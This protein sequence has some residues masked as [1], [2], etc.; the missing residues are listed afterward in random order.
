MFSTTNV[1]REINKPNRNEDFNKLLSI[2]GIRTFAMVFIIGVHS[3][4]TAMTL[5]FVR[6]PEYFEDVSSHFLCVLDCFEYSI[7]LPIWFGIWFVYTRSKR[8]HCDI[9]D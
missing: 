4:F 3:F 1:W 9:S 7:Y 5:K 6:N 2:Q 8:L